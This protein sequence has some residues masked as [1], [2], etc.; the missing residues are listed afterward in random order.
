M[1]NFYKKKQ[2]LSEIKKFPQLK[3]IYPIYKK[4]KKI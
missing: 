2:K 1:S 4:I 3:K